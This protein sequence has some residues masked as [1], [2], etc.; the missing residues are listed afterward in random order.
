M[1]H[2]R[3]SPRPSTPRHRQRR[4]LL[5][6]RILM[7]EESILHRLHHTPPLNMNTRL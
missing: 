7:W 3:I 4:R 2:P 1:P 6:F 5:R